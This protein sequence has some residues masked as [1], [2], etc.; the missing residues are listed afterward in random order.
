MNKI[1][2][3]PIICEFMVENFENE[4]KY[5]RC[6]KKIQNIKKNGE[7]TK[8]DGSYREEEIEMKGG[9]KVF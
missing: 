1:F 7:V 6:L 2:K 8:W 4:Y 5:I 9:E 3:N